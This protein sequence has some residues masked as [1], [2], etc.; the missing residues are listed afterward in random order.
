MPLL[1]MSIRPVQVASA[2]NN[3]QTPTILIHTP[4]AKFFH[5]SD[6]LKPPMPLLSTRPV[7]VASAVNSAHIP[8]ILIHTPLAKFLRLG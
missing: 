2:V 5:S 6:T 3:A 1:K 8:T 7:R 4:L